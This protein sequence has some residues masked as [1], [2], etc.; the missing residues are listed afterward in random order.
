MNYN[1]TY[2]Y[3]V[4][5]VNHAADENSKRKYSRLTYNDFVNMNGRF[6]F[7]NYIY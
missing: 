5:L 7:F 1:T 6:L 4:Q 3:R 2:K